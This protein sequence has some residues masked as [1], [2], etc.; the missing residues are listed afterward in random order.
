MRSEVTY[1]GTRGWHDSQWPQV[2]AVVI[3]EKVVEAVRATVRAGV[4]GGGVPEAAEKGKREGLVEDDEGVAGLPEGVEEGDLPGGDGVGG[5]RGD[6]GH[7]ARLR[8]ERGLL[9]A[10]EICTR[11]WP[12]PVCRSPVARLAKRGHVRAPT[13]RALVSPGESTV[14]ALQ[15]R[16]SLSPSPH[17]LHPPHIVYR[18]AS[19]TH[20]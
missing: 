16:M 5:R 2:F 1:V 8:A 7:Q 18:D 6:S 3:L 15:I 4:P 11:L 17:I 19:D 13:R 9:R 20:G 14:G 10:R 12:A